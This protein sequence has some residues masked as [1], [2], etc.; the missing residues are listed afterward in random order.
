MKFLLMQFSLLASHF[1]FLM[2]HTFSAIYVYTYSTYVFFLTLRS[3]VVTIFAA[4]FDTNETLHSVRTMCYNCEFLMMHRK[5]SEFSP[6]QVSP[7]GR[8]DR[9]TS[10][11][12]YEHNMYI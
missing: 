5:S 12:R 7:I 1:S 2:P 4:R 10:F 11:V 8:S 3:L 6:K 9:S